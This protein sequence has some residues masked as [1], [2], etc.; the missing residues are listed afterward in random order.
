MTHY[1]YGSGEYGC[2]YDNGPYL[3]ESVEDAIESLACTFDLGR[4]RK[5]TLRRDRYLDLNPRRDGA[6]YCEINQC[7]CDMLD[8]HKGD[9]P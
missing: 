5:A 6:E 9:E 7:D 3:A 4:T 2:L 1:I 8:D